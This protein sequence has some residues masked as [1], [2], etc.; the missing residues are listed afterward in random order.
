MHMC[1]QKQRRVITQGPCQCAAFHYPQFRASNR[2]HRTFGDVQI[3]REIPRFAHHNLARWIK[4]KRGDNQ[5]VQVYGGGIRR[6]HLIRIRTDQRRNHCANA[7][8]R[9]DPAFIPAT[10]Q[11]LAPCVGYRVGACRRRR[12]WQLPKRIAIEINDAR[13]THELHAI[14][15][16]RVGRIHRPRLVQCHSPNAF[17]MT[18]RCLRQDMVSGAISSACPSFGVVTIFAP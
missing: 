8:R 12:Q 11:P 5:L 1:E 14:L 6:D 13:R 2:R 4:P 7:L 3:G 16:Q 15:R 9:I 17:N 18:A 10:D